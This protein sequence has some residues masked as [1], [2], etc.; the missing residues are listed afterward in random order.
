[1]AGFLW[2]PSPL[3]VSYGGGGR[4]GNSNQ[5]WATSP[6]RVGGRIHLYKR[7]SVPSHSLV[8]RLGRI[9][10]SRRRST[11]PTAPIR[12]AVNNNVNGKGG[13]SGSR[14]DFELN[15]RYSDESNR[16]PVTCPECSGTGERECQWCHATGLLTL[17]DKL[18]CSIDGTTKCLLC[19]DGAVQCRK[20][21]GSGS[22]A[23][24]LLM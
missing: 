12:A 16:A 18:I 19:N 14:R 3:L 22:I 7:F 21:R 9:Q 8:P 2:A 4:R 13:T 15:F 1:M 20:C 23:G 5:F 10:G 24:W 11:T 6:S 17:G